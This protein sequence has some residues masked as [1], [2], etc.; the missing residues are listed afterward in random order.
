MPANWWLTTFLKVAYTK[1]KFDCYPDDNKNVTYAINPTGLFCTARGNG[2]RPWHHVLH[3]QRS[4][5]FQ[6]SVKVASF[7]NYI[8]SFLLKNQCLLP[9]YTGFKPLMFANKKMKRGKDRS[10]CINTRERQFLIHTS[11]SI[12]LIL[13]MD[14]RRKVK[15]SHA[16][17]DS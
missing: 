2:L 9:I 7:C 12:P 10:F 16:K 17:N 3:L 6:D 14:K 13:K 5:E 4:G 1:R 15:K 8:L 11:I